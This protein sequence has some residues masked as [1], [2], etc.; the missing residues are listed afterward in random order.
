MSSEDTRR[1]SPGSEL[2]PA[3]RAEV[4]KARPRWRA[5]IEGG[6][7]LAVAVTAAA[8]DAAAN[9]RER[10]AGGLGDTILGLALEGQRVALDLT[11]HVVDAGSDVARAVG[12]N[13]IARAVAEPAQRMTA[14]LR[15]QG[16][17]A[18][19]DALESA[20]VLAPDYASRMVDTVI[21]VVSLNEVL[22]H[23]DLDALLAR[24]DVQG[25]IDRVDIG[26]L[27][28][29]VDVQQIIDRVD[30]DSL[31]ARVDVGALLDRVDVN[32]IIEQVDIE[33][34]VEQTELGAIIARST[35]GMASEALDLV[36]RQG[37]GLDGFVYRWSK[38]VR[39]RALKDAPVGPP[40]LIN[41]PAGEEPGR[42]P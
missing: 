34:L 26:K 9:G 13:R 38:R 28:E 18:R 32:E 37:V 31:M 42:E 29:R 15:E 19:T 10:P 12:R 3:R 36:R 6:T 25:I 7:R 1:D 11:E 27:L 22:A 24:I 14:P 2:V 23:V 40:L 35:G 8:T 17:E 41:P 20:K 39:R 33:A 4:V 21:D 16:R 30:I 5:A